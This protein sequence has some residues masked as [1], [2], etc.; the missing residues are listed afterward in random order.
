MCQVAQAE[1]PDWRVRDSG[2][3]AGCGARHS[4]F[5]NGA[6]QV[7]GS[8]PAFAYIRSLDVGQGRFYD[9]G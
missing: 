4:N 8:Y 2:T 7:T 9:W 6:L 5:N 3:G 1:S